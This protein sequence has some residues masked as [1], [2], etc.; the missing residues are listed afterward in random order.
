MPPAPGPTIWARC[1]A[2]PFASGW[3]ALGLAGMLGL[4]YSYVEVWVRPRK[5]ARIGAMVATVVLM[6]LTHTTDVGSTFLAAMTPAAD[7]WPLAQQA[8]AN[9]WPAGLWALFLT[10]IPEVLI[11]GGAA[12][13][14]R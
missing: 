4:C 6:L 7:A 12:Q 10:Y 9:V 3:W 2:L 8:A 11:V 5:S 14:R 1:C 13:F